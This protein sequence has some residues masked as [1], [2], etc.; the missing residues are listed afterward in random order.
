MTH[1]QYIELRKLAETKLNHFPDYQT[2]KNIWERSVYYN[3]LQ[4]Q[5]EINEVVLSLSWFNEESKMAEYFNIRTSKQYNRKQ[6][7]IILLAN[8]LCTYSIQDIRTLL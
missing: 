6:Y 3:K 4:N 1:I 2:C 7:F 5:L 8:A